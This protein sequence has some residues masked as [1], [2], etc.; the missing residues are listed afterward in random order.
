M[1]TCVF[2]KSKNA[3]PLKECKPLLHS[4]RTLIW[5]SSLNWFFFT[6]HQ[7]NM[8]DFLEFLF[9]CGECGSPK[10]ERHCDFCN[11]SLCVPCIGK[12]F[13][14]S[15]KTHNA[16]PFISFKHDTLGHTFVRCSIDSHS[17][18]G[19]N[20]K[21]DRFCKECNVPVCS[22]CISSGGHTYHEVF[23]LR[24]VPPKQNN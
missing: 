13:A 18:K 16:V 1:C 20:R 3:Y 24:R 19:V 11:T 10:V 4:N 6:Q 21:C 7:I 15:R 17:V 5:Y 22:K 14:D 8:S 23:P 12:H 9:S 2:E